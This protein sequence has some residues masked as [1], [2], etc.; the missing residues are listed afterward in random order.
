MRSATLNGYVVGLTTLLSIALSAPASS[1][2]CP[3]DSDDDCLTTAPF[4]MPHVQNAINS[5]GTSCDDG[6]VIDVLV[7][8]TTG[9]RSAAGG[10]AQIEAL[11]N[12]AIADANAAFA[13]SGV[14]ITL[15]LVHSQE[16]AYTETGV[17]QTDGPRL[18]DPHDGYLDE[19]HPIRDEYGADCVSLWVA[20]LNTGGIGFFPDSS[21]RGVG[22]SG[23]SMLYYGAA[24]ELTFAH[25]IGHN[26]WC[27]HDRPHAPDPPYADY[28]FGFVEPGGFWQ[29]LMAVSATDYIPYFSNPAVSW[30]GPSPGSPGPTGVAIGDPNACD[31]ATTMNLTRHI[32]ANF[33][34]TRVFGLGPVLRVS[35]AATPGGDGASWATALN[36]LGEAG[37]L[38]AG[39]NGAVSEVWVAAGRYT[40]DLAGGSKSPNEGGSGDRDTSFKLVNGVALYGGFSGVETSLAQRNAY[41]RPTILSGDI[42]VAGDPNDNSRHVIDA[43]YADASAVIDGFVIA[44]GFAD[45]SDPNAAGGGGLLCF[46]GSPTFVNCVFLGN[47]GTIAGGAVNLRYAA[48]PTFIDCTFRDNHAT[49]PDWPAGGGAVHSYGGCSPNF[50]R[51]LFEDNSGSFGG[52]VSSFYQ[53]A[54]ALRD[55]ILRGNAAENDGGALY[56]YG[57]APATLVNCLLAG[58]AAAYGGAMNNLFQSNA[59][60]VNTALLGNTASAVSGG[61]YNYQSDPSLANAILW[62]NAA[63]ALHDEWAQ[64]SAYD[65]T[66]AIN[67]SSVEGWTGG[68]GGTG[69]DGD[70]PFFVDADGPDGLYGT[71]DDNPRI[72]S[73]SPTADSGDDAAVPAG[74]A[75]DLDGRPRFNGTVD[76]GP[77][78]RRSTFPADIDGDGDRDIGDLGALLGCL[79]GEGIATAIGCHFADLAGDGDVD[80]ADA[81]SF[82]L[83]YTP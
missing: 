80:L 48:A 79:H 15:R 29:T 66:P 8:Y 4:R 32:V 41:G 3:I 5:L 40:P 16:V 64:I 14:D 81:W 56:A 6:S 46:A 37:C 73:D 35:A 42:G 70:E 74:V 38:A 20:N 25:E 24:T 51:C 83:A 19:V 43:S 44:G 10:A 54:P 9:A 17:W 39:S 61:I 68:Y 69:S 21:L 33:R 75:T 59:S 30:P 53:C 78:E 45:D 49:N 22:N 11:I 27:A 7:V 60:L 2:D 57:D 52:A 1:I 28:S 13:R 23:F 63:G 82:Q 31:N 65:S 26:L 47:R 18:V 12:T 36:D 58:N 76:R 62:D 50:V 67:N 72:W 77:F 71:S 34:P 55:C